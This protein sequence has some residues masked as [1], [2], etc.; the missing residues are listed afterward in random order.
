MVDTAMWT[1]RRVR[2]S[3]LAARA[4]LSF[5]MSGPIRTAVPGLVA[6]GPAGLAE[7]LAVTS[8]AV[9]EALTELTDKGLLEVD[10]EAPL[11]RVVDG[12]RW[13]GAPNPKI[14]RAWTRL[15]SDLPPSPLV[16]RHLASMRAAAA[17]TCPPEL[18]SEVFGGMAAREPNGSADIDTPSLPYP[19]P[20]DRPSEV[21]PRARAPSASA[22]APSSA[23]ATAP[24]TTPAADADEGVVAV[25]EHWSSTLWKRFHDVAPKLTDGRRKKIRSR[26]GEGYTVEQ[27]K[28]AIDAVTRSPH[29]MGEND[30]GKAWI[31]IDLVFR[32]AEKVDGWLTK[33]VTPIRMNGRN[34]PLQSR[35][36]APDLEA[37]YGVK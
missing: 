12:V 6:I 37:L 35:E 26:L 10:T 11:V 24:T 29:H 30:Q 36:G 31:E 14:V 8:E 1:D 27:L 21:G 28:A 17:V 3:A 7:A 34:G 4:V 13:D 20:I 19:N 2:S 18:V 23:S 22:S 33:P 5:L 25:F 9:V 16:G 15:V 32:N